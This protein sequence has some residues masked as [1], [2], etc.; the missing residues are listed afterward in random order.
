MAKVLEV[1]ADGGEAVFGMHRLSRAVLY[2]SKR[3][4]AVDALGR[5]CANASLTHDGCFI[6]PAG[7]TTQV[8]LDECGDAVE[9]SALDFA[10]GLS[11]ALMSSA[12]TQDIP[13]SQGDR[14]QRAATAW[15]LLLRSVV[16]C[17]LCG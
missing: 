3:R 12:V 7:S 1:A 16:V 8:Y 9:R 13:K 14:A 10:G 2:G 6:L 4:V 5:E 15:Y 11:A 17:A